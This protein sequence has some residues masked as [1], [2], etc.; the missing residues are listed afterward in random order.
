ME[1]ARFQ[2]FERRVPVE[3]IELAGTLT[4]PEGPPAPAV[5][6]LAGTMADMRD[7]NVDPARFPT[8]SDKVGSQPFGLFRPL[9]R[10]LGAA[11]IASFRFD[12]RGAG[13]STGVHE[14]D[15]TAGRESEIRDAAAVWAWLGD[16]KEVA[17]AVAMAGHSAGA[18]V[19]CRLA[20]TGN[21]PRAAVLM[22]ALSQPIPE[23]LAWTFGRARDFI[24]RGD[25]ERRWLKAMNPIE[26]ENGIV[27]DEFL[28]ALE[29]GGGTVR[30][31]KYGVVVERAVED[32]AYDRAYPPEE[33]FR[34]VTC[35][36]LVIHGAEDM[37]TR[38]DDAFRTL[39]ALWDAGNRQVEFHLVPG[40]GHGFRLVAEDPE[41]R[42]RDRLGRT[43]ARLPYHPSY[44]RVIVDFLAERLLGVT[45]AGHS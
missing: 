27:A 17:G 6:M 24:A 13:A 36:T 45:S 8:P 15:A 1:T 5:L 41:D 14:P 37:N 25:E 30:V 44:P 18:Y 10:A 7:G 26:F 31:K 22:G 12:K 28:K 20:A 34:Y 4:L 19:L 32:M 11:G 40:A 9:A 33:Q 16:S 43:A 23:F 38:V 21:V 2:E 39:H 35:P 42:L 3:G 29:S